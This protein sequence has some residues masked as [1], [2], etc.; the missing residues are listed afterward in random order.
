VSDG[1]RSMPSSELVFEAD[2]EADQWL[3]LCDEA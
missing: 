3:Y 1:Y 2:P